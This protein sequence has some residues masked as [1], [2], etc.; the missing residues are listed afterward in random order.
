MMAATTERRASG[1]STKCPAARRWVPSATVL[2]LVSRDF[3][4][5]SRLVVAI[6]RFLRRTEAAAT[7][8]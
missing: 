7:V 1:F 5:V 6:F 3:G 4:N 8:R 2:L